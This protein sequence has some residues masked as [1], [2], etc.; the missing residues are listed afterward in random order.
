LALAAPFIEEH[1][2]AR[3]GQWVGIHSCKTQECLVKNNNNLP[4]SSDFFTVAKQ[5]AA[6]PLDGESVPRFFIVS[7]DVQ[8]EEAIKEMI[9]NM[10][11]TGAKGSA[12]A[13]PCNFKFTQPNSVAGLREM[14][15]QL[16]LLSQTV[17]VI[18]TP[19]SSFSN[20]AA[21]A[22]ESYLVFAEGNNTSVSGSDSG[23]VSPA[24]T[25]GLRGALLEGTGGS[26]G[27]SAK[28]VA[29]SRHMSG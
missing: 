23:F 4:Q 6:L 26:G 10:N 3:W 7:D 14:V 20:A 18:G 9:W 24:E 28:A 5:F 21:A 13:F 2:W 29:K 27:G 19:E 1:Q 12:I 15:V 25:G 17:L 22:G 11:L 8:E 16:H